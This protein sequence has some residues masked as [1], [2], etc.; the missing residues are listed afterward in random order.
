MAWTK[1]QRIADDSA[2]WS[3]L[4]TPYMQSGGA[5]ASSRLLSD[6]PCSDLGVGRTATNGAEE[7]RKTERK[8]ASHTELPRASHH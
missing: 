2:P 3:V 7:R 4:G 8:V 6:V 5:T 1:Q